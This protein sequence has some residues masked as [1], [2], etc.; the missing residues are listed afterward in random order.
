MTENKDGFEL[1]TR[2]E[3]GGIKWAIIQTAESWVKCI[4]A[5]I[6]ERRA[7]DEEKKNDFSVSSIREYLNGDFLKKIVRAGAPEEAFLPFNIDLTADDG[8]QNYGGD[9]VRVGLITCDEYRALRQNIPAVDG[10]WWT[11]TP[12]S[13]INSFVRSVISD[14]VMNSSSAYSGSRGVRPLCNLKSEI[15]KSFLDGGSEERKAAVKM[16]QQLSDKWN[17][18]EE[19]IFG[20]DEE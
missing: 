11:A 12:D 16:V 14:G 6:V 2:F 3:M 7:F 9:R 10:W 17:I 4:A 18:S 13:P 19:E 20:R 8:L 1:G 5:E 15:L